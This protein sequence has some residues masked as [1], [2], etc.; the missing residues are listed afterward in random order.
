MYLLVFQH[1]G[2]ED[3]LELDDD[4]FPV[5]PRFSESDYISHFAENAPFVPSA[6]FPFN[7]S[8]AENPICK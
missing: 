4:I 8:F 2:R 7:D 5:A 1:S 6:L 3:V